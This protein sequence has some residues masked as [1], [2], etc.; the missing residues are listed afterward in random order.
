[1]K[2][3]WLLCEAEL[4]V[5][6]SMVC[7]WYCKAPSSSVQAD[8]CAGAA[9]WAAR[10]AVSLHRN[11]YCVIRAPPRKNGLVSHELCAT[12]A[13]AAA[14]RLE[15]LLLWAEESGIDTL[16]QRFLFRELCQRSPRALRYD[17]AVPLLVG[18]DSSCVERASISVITE[19]PAR[20]TR[21]GLA[22]LPGTIACG[23]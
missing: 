8:V 14:S 11:G 10:A 17:M 9:G 2:Q 13:A 12:V 4:A 7:C 3:N 16:T 20:S 5:P 22:G 18:S 15:R 19:M 23:R 1:M 6:L 21:R